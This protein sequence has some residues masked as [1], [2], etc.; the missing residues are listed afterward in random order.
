MSLGDFFSDDFRE[1]FARRSIDIGAAVLLRIPEF[2]IN[3]EKYGI[4]FANDNEDSE[5]CG[6]VIIN[7]PTDVVNFNPFLR[8][9]QVLIDCARHNFLG[10]DSY[11]DCTKLRRTNIQEMVDCIKLDPS[12]LL[13]N[14]ETDIMSQI[15]HLLLNSET[16]DQRTKN[17][18]SIL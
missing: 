11:V 10:Y 16:I 14:V 13:G 12:K 1:S 18:Y 9:Q 2:R 17:R 3:Y 15:Y 6:L 7:S 4:Y 8:S 5:F